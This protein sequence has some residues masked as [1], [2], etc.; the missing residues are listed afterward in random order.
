M[1][2]YARLFET[3][4]DGE[5]AGVGPGMG[6]RKLT[7]REG[8]RAIVR[9]KKARFWELLACT[10]RGASLDQFEKGA[11]W[12]YNFWEHPNCQERERLGDYYWDYG[13]GIR[14]WAEHHGGEVIPIDLVDVR[15]GHF[16]G[17]GN[18]KYVAL[19]PR[20]WRKDLAL[21]LNANFDLAACCNQ[22]NL[23][24]LLIAD[25]ELV[26]TAENQSK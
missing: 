8:L 17:S 12:W 7:S 15:E 18:A 10:T 6:W 26:S 9:P 23:G 25:S 19:S 16:T 11:S 24:H 1:E 21:D 22:L 20:D 3:L 4:R 2:R 5:A 14:Y 13:V